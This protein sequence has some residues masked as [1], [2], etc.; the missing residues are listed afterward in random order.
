[1]SICY[2]DFRYITFSATCFIQ[3][4]QPSLNNKDELRLTTTVERMQEIK[5]CYSAQLII[6]ALN[7]EQGI[8]L[9]ITEMKDVLGDIPTLVV[10]G[11]SAD[12]TVELSKNLGATVITQDGKGKGDAL[13]KAIENLD[14]GTDYVILT[15]ADYTYPAEYIPDMIKILEENPD[16]GMVCGN[17]FNGN[18]D[19][20]ALYRIFHIGNKLLAFAHKALNGIAL[21]D[22]LTGLRVVRTEILPQ[23]HIESKGFD[24]EIELNNFVQKQGYTTREIL[25]NYRE[26]LGE[27]KLR[28]RDGFTILKRILKDIF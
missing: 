18:V 11:K 24:I 12:K 25:I 5:S 1:M 17:R 3:H 13:A 8:G 19:R 4:S 22:P 14:S 20:K 21:E 28:A 7:E 26:R 2:I 16:V 15:D 6:A 23:W 27:K 9:T 10:D